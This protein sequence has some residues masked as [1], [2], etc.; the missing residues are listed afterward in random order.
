MHCRILSLHQNV[1]LVV[2]T[3]SL[4]LSPFVL[5][6]G[7]TFFKYIWVTG[8][9]S[10]NPVRKGYVCVGWGGYLGLQNY[11]YAIVFIRFAPDIP[12]ILD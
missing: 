4:A 6:T 8:V 12:R 10:M 11:R 9:S 1:A 3:R 7:M 5:G 2:W